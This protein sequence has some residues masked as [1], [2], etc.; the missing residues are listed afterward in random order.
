QDIVDA[1]NSFDPGNPD[2]ARS[3][4]IDYFVHAW[5]DAEVESL[6]VND[7]ARD[8]RDYLDRDQDMRVTRADGSKMARRNLDDAKA[9]SLNNAQ[10]ANRYSSFDTVDADGNAGKDGRMNPDE[11]DAIYG[12]HRDGGLTVGP[13]M[14]LQRFPEFAAMVKPAAPKA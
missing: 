8:S 14:F 3:D 7:F 2:M 10:M 1:I 4:F 9:A 5:N 12:L 11:V 13:A 6:S